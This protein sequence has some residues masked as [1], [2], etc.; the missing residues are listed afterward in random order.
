MFFIIV[1]WMAMN[2]A[3][4]HLPRPEEK[5]LEVIETGYE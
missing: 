3:R 4:L 1:F 5:P 2:K